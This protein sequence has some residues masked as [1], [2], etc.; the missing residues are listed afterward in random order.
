MADNKPQD[1][2]I[3]EEPA[4]EQSSEQET[5]DQEEAS[6]KEE[7]SDQEEASD[8]EEASDQEEASDEEEAS[9]QE[10]QEK[11]SGDIDVGK[12]T[13]KVTVKKRGMNDAAKKQ[14]DKYVTAK[15]VLGQFG[16]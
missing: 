5:N 12:S 15:V 13:S 7:A 6:D 4:K 10:E 3:D 1:M 9:D 8:E 16:S 11:E 2:E 14:A